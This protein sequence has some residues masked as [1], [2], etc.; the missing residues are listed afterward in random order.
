MKS[1]YEDAPVHGLNDIEELL[2][3][4]LAGVLQGRSFHPPQPLQLIQHIGSLGVNQVDAVEQFVA[5]VEP[6]VRL[7]AMRH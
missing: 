5:Y 6:E 1:R 2:A 4:V 7:L 3:G